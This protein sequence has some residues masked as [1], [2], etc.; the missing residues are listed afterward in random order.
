MS[1]TPKIN[2]WMHAH[3]SK[4]KSKL[5]KITLPP[6]TW[7]AP[8]WSFDI[9]INTSKFLDR[10]PRPYESKRLPIQGHLK[11]ESMWPKNKKKY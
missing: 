3:K 5:P 9:P 11:D 6:D 10:S 2:K 4:P 1:R 7:V 8:N